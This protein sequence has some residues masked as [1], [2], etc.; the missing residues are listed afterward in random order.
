MLYLLYSKNEF[1]ALFHHC[2]LIMHQT[3]WLNY[4]SGQFVASLNHVNSRIVLES[5]NTEKN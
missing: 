3:E 2:K 1:K 5:L 4:S